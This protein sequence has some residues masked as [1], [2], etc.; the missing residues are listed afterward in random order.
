M[1]YTSKIEKTE[2]QYLVNFPDFENI[3]TYGKTLENAILN[4][5]EALNGSL[6]TDFDRGFNLPM[7]KSKKGKRLF[8][9]KVALNI[10]V[11]H[12]LRNLRNGQSQTEIAKKLGVS[13]QSYQKLENPRLS[14][15]TLKTLQK[16]SKVFGRQ[17][18]VKFI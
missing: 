18:E 16:L 8:P 12:L 6:E 11:A 10:E 2:G 17:V 14:N 9:I 4:A 3:N 5:E 7:P 15:P 13:Y 1:Y